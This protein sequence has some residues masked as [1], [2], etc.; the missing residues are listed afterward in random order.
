[1][2]VT[3]E[4]CSAV[5]RTVGVEPS[6]VG[7]HQENERLN[8]LKRAIR[9]LEHKKVDAQSTGHYGAVQEMQKFLGKATPV[10]LTKNL[11]QMG[12]LA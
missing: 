6:K 7:Y 11:M 5:Q 3:L 4:H 12:H 1:M 2:Q 8:T 9:I 10:L